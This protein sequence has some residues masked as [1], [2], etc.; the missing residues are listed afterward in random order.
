MNHAKKHQILYPLQHGF[1]KGRSCETQL[2]EFTDDITQNMENG[3]QTD[4]LS[5]DFAKAY[6]KVCHSLLAHKLEHYGIKGRNNLWIQAFLSRRYQSVVLIGVTSDTVSVE[7][8]VPQGSVCFSSTSTSSLKVSL[9][10]SDYLTPWPT[11]LSPISPTVPPY[12]LTLTNYSWTS[13][14]RSGRDPEKYFD[15]GMVQDKQLGIMGSQTFWPIFSFKKN[16]Y[17][18]ASFYHLKFIR[19]LECIK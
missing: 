6:D 16:A 18:Q 9:Q 11:L 17:F 13:L 19:S 1:R 7:S 14:F 8:G 10:S 5:M 12:K 4:V 3:K 15:I 2:L